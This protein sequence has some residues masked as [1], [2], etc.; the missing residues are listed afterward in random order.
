MSFLSLFLYFL[1][2]WMSF[3]SLKLVFSLPK[4]YK[5]KRDIKDSDIPPLNLHLILFK[6]QVFINQICFRCNRWGVSTDMQISFLK[7]APIGQHI[8]IVGQCDK[9]GKTLA[10]S[11]CFIYN[12]KG[13]LL[14]RGQQTKFMGTPLIEF[15]TTDELD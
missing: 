13:E 9:A 2:F 5:E 1:S 8:D 12:D 7:A 3:F 11:S 6:K 4:R 10:F 14:L 15:E